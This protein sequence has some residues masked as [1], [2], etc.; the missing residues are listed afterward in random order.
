MAGVS[1]GRA[2]P[3]PPRW[4]PGIGKRRW[5]G[6][7]LGQLCAA[8]HPGVLGLGIGQVRSLIGCCWER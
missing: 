8:D 4:L 7:A 3:D 2:T 1:S 5:P 6:R